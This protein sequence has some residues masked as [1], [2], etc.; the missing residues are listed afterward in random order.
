VRG[1]ERR[2]QTND[3]QRKHYRGVGPGIQQRWFSACPDVVDLPQRRDLFRNRWRVNR[4]W[5]PEAAILAAAIL[6]WTKGH[7]MPFD[8]VIRHC[9]SASFC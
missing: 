5:I 7:V 9:V 1:N 2:D 8:T 4:G 3:R 6:A